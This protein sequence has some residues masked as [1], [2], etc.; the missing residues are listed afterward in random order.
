MMKKMTAQTVDPPL[1]KP[2]PQQ[3]H[4]VTTISTV[5]L[6]SNKPNATR[7]YTVDASES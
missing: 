6:I 3:R 2:L 5:W 4:L 7:P 1:F